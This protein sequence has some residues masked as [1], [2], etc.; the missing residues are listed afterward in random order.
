MSSA[1]IFFIDR[2]LGK[3]V[4]RSLQ[5]IGRNVEFHN[6]HFAPDSPDIEWLPIVSQKEWI[7]LTKDSQIRYNL[8]EQLAIANNQARV[9][10]LSGQ[11]LSTSVMFDIFRHSIEGMERF[12]QG[13]Q[14]PFIAKIY[15][16]A[17]IE[18]WRSN[19]ELEKLARFHHLSR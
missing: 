1:H 5:E 16:T 6:D 15:K 8:S 13:N 18:L 3:S 12:I 19:K 14:S 9:F 4:G 7:I 11:N 17:R 2:A 10:I